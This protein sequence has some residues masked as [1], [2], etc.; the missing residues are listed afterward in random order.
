[1]ILVDKKRIYDQILLRN[2]RLKES[3]DKYQNVKFMF[4][5]LEQFYFQICS[6]IEK[7]EK[8]EYNLELLIDWKTTMIDL[9]PFE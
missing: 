4:Q 9:K 6:Q 1:M 2:K 8:N 5:K 3:H 7:F